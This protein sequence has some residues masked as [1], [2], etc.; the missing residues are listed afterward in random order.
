VIEKIHVAGMKRGD[1]KQAASFAK[2]YGF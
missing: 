2:K 1:Y